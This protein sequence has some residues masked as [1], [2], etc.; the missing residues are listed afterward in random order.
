MTESRKGT[1]RYRAYDIRWGG[2]PGNAER[3]PTIVFLDLEETGAELV[4]AA[5]RVLSSMYGAIVDDFELEECAIPSDREPIPLSDKEYL[6]HGGAICP[7]CYGRSIDA[8]DAIQQDGSTAFQRI[9][10][11]DC[12]YEWDDMWELRGY[13]PRF[14]GNSQEA[15]PEGK[16]D[17][18]PD[19]YLQVI[20]GD[21]DPSAPEGPFPTEEQRDMRAREMKREWGDENGIYMLDIRQ[22]GRPEMNAYSNGFFE[23]DD[24]EG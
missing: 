5:V 14:V 2:N 9:T 19:M 8:P 21:T 4:A 24:D 3:L 13:E 20:W 22:D 16:P 6:A 1:M 18:Q 23:E 11:N 12:E 7:K 17:S 15:D 10:C